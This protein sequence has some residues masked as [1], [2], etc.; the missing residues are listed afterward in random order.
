[1]KSIE[2][3][4]EIIPKWRDRYR[5]ALNAKGLSLRGFKRL[6]LMLDSWIE[7]TILGVPVE[8]YFSYEFYLRNRQGRNTFATGNRLWNLYDTLNDKDYWEKIDF[9]TNLWDNYSSLM[10]R[11]H[12]CVGTANYDEFRA[13]TLRNSRFFVKPA[14]EDC[15]TGCKV[16]TCASDSEAKEVYSWLHKEDYVAE[17]LV[18]QCAEFD[19]FNSSA[20]N[21][22]RIMS[23]VNKNG[24]V[25]LFPYGLI[26]FGR[27]GKVVSNFGRNNDGISS[28]IDIRSGCAVGQA[29]DHYGKKYTEHPDSGKRIVGFQI[30]VWEK[31]CDVAKR[32]ALIFPKLRMVGWDIAVTKSYEAIIIEGNRRPGMISYQIDLVGKWQIL[33]DMVSK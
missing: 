13:F 31:V 18:V 20:L 24:E 30:P 12:V 9:K 4:N 29:Y 21:T 8:E 17:E 22:I 26:R 32:A 11:D 2:N 33:K 3:K 1:M 27:K 16:L 15:G 28:P 25:Q 10:K 23:Y 6:V 14:D 19:E 7:D 5:D